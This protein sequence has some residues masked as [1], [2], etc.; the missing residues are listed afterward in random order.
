MGISRSDK[1][2][3]KYVTK[4]SSATCQQFGISIFSWAV[5]THSLLSSASCHMS[6]AAFNDLKD[7]LHDSPG[8]P[9]RQLNSTFSK[10]VWSKWCS[11]RDASML[12]D[13][14]CTGFLVLLRV[15]EFTIESLANFPE[16]VHIT[17]Q[18]ISI[19]SVTSPTMIHL[20]LKQSK[21]DPFCH[22]TVITLG[23]TQQDIVQ[24]L[25]CSPT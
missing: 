11:R 25:L 3:G 6:F 20:R 24:Y 12:W 22:G 13:A 4:Q 10:R 7:L 8:C 19:D 1:Q 15:G 5:A 18:D 14:F 17:P 21:T 16:A 2:I 9:L 23:C